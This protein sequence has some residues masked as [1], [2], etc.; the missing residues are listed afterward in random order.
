MVEGN[1][2]GLRRLN[3]IREQVGLDPIPTADAESFSSLKLKETELVEWLGTRFEIG[4]ERFFGTYYLISRVVHPL[5]VH[6]NQPRF[7]APINAIARKVAE[8]LPDV[9]R[10]GHVAGYQL[11]ARK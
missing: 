5:L 1:E 4:E 7:D 10:L 6:P 2:D 11:I 8:A 3:V 9:G